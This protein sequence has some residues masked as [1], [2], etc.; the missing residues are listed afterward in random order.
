MKILILVIIILLLLILI[1]I[2]IK[3]SMF[4]SNNNYY[5]KVYN[6]NIISSKKSKKINKF[7]NRNLNR[8]IDRISIDNR[9]IDFNFYKLFLKK[10]IFNL[11]RN[12]HKAKI[13]F[14]GE[15]SYSLFDSFNTAIF[16]GILSAFFSF[17][18]CGLNI[19]FK[20]KKSKLNI[21]PVF[22]DTLSINFYCKSI[23]FLSLG[24]VIYMLL[25]FLKTYLQVKEVTLFKG[26]L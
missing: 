20:V 4:Y 15:L 13:K 1:P 12:R 3:I 21:K 14:N 24:K 26:R 9:N 2:P 25:I 6:F 18:Y 19:P 10:L 11:K 8:L 5:I 23:I 7:V 22:K 16:Y 17:I